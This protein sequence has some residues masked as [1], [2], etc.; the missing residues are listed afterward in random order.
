MSNVNI[1]V[2]LEHS[3]CWSNVES[4]L[5]QGVEEVVIPS[6]IQDI[7]N[8]AA[9]YGRV[10]LHPL[11]ERIGKILKFDKASQTLSAQEY[12]PIL[13]QKGNFIISD[14]AL[15]VDRYQ[16]EKMGVYLFRL[17]QDLDTNIAP[18]IAFQG[19]ESSLYD[20]FKEPKL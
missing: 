8:K 6:G 7:L 18:L 1:Y 4:V 13:N 15:I 10:Y 20:Y 14:N 5:S 17:D 16:G 3:L 12:L 11:D 2:S 19:L 9:E